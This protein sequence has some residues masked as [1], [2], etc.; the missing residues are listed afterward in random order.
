MQN[1]IAARDLNVFGSVLLELVLPIDFAAKPADVE[2]LGFFHV[3]DRQDRTSA[4]ELPWRHGQADAF[5]EKV[6]FAPQAGLASGR[7]QCG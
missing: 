7:S 6:I 4:V 3:E 5:T 2:L 1:Q